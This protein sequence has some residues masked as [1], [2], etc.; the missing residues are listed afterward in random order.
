M[1]ILIP[2]NDGKQVWYNMENDQQQCKLYSRLVNEVKTRK[3]YLK[4]LRCRLEFLRKPK[5]AVS[6]PEATAVSLEMTH[7]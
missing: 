5:A 1:L 4:V 3:H 2:G 7:R 6:A